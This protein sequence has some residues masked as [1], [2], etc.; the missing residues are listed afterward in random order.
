MCIL[1][2]SMLKQID[3][4][5]LRKSMGQNTDVYVKSFSGAKVEC[6][7]SYVVPSMKKENNVYILHCGTNDLRSDKPAHKIADEIIQLAT[8]IKK[9]GN[10]VFVSG[11]ISRSDDP[12]LDE[13][14]MNV[15]EIVFS[16]SGHYGIEFINNNNINNS[17]LNYSGLHL[18]RKGTVE[19]AK[20]YIDFLKY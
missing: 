18:N 6:M 19:L 20:N 17:H 7:S 8:Y 14:G 16:V 3:S 4:R 15:N 11:I 2:D 5:K 13:K 1:G 10:E 12:V 9:E